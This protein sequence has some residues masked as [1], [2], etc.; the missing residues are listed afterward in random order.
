MKIDTDN[1]VSLSEANRN[2][3]R[4]ARLADDAGAVIIMRNNTPSYLLMTF[5]QAELEQET[6]DEDVSDIARRISDGTKGALKA[7]AK[8][9][10]AQ[11]M[12][13][14]AL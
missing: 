11:S 4:V 5:T 10:E 14:G 1:I 7:A 6:S 9:K 8:P 13:A 12:K 2:F 3:S